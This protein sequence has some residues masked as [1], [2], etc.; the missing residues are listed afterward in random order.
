MPRPKPK[1][2]NSKLDEPVLASPDKAIKNLD[3]M[4]DTVIRVSNVRVREKIEQEK[5]RNTAKRQR[6]VRETQGRK[7]S[8]SSLPR[9]DSTK[10]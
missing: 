4:F 9:N 5:R 8:A 7:R 1:A 3:R 10:S 2:A 6:R